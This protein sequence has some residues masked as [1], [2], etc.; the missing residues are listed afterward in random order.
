MKVLRVLLVLA[1]V[2]FPGVTV[3]KAQDLPG[4]AIQNWPVPPTWTRD[5]QHL[6]KR[7]GASIQTVGAPL[8]FLDVTPCRIADT[9][10]NGFTGAYGPPSLAAN[11]SRTFV[12]TG[13]CGIPAT[14][15]AVSFNF[16]ASNVSAAGDLRVFPPGIVP[17][18]STLNYNANTPNIANAAI[19]PLGSGGAIT[20]LADATAIDLIIDVNGYFGTPASNSGNNVFLGPAAGNS[21]MVGTAN[22]GLGFGVLNELVSGND[23]TAV[24][25]AALQTDSGGS[26]NSA[27]GFEALISNHSGGFNTAV[28]WDALFHNNASNNTAVGSEALLNNSSG[29]LNVA[30]GVGALSNNTTG[31]DNIAIGT[32][33]GAALAS[34]SDNIHIGNPALISESNTIRIGTGGTHTKFF[35]AG[36]RN[37]TTG[38]AN[39]LPVMID[40]VAQLGTVSS[41]A[42][43]KRQ[44][45]DVGDDSSAIFRLRPVSFYYRNDTVGYRQYGLIAEEVAQV[46]PDLVQYSDSGDPETVRYHFLPAL[47]LNELQKQQRIIEEQKE[48]IAALEARLTR[49]EARLSPDPER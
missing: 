14:A 34:G 8:P 45:A 30:I 1:L 41:S 27:L 37:V 19:V 9:R 3:T 11:A 21:T 33:S 36:V 13:H 42:R 35:V 48:T 7:G 20:V 5:A 40:G 49:L 12:I 43:V 47:L 24:G 29:G 22:V 18:V 17:L 44:I 46:M 38:Q 2:G 28:G 6:S 25:T 39:A 15:E 10:G 4:D 32:N 26:F 23:N 31:S 16:T